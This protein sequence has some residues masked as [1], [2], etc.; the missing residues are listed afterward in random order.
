MKRLILLICVLAMLLPLTGITSASPEEDE[1][2]TFTITGYTCY[3]GCYRIVK[4]RPG[5]QV[6]FYLTAVGTVS[7]HL[8]G[9]FTF[10]EWGEIDL[11]PTGKD[12]GKGKNHGIMTITNNQGQV[13]I[14]FHGKAESGTV[15]GDFEVVPEECSGDYARL[16]GRGQY[17]GNAGFN[18]TV[19]FTGELHHGD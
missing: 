1:P 10:E 18:F 9:A 8:A 5:M 12:Y 19:T 14:A 15:S 2:G 13:V 11:N 4:I 17:T 16:A 7:G 6:E 3:A